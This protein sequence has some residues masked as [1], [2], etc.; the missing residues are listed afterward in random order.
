VFCREVHR[1][2]GIGALMERF[3]GWRYP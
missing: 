2:R 1:G 3:Q